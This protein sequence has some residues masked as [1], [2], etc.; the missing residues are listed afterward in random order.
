MLADPADMSPQER[1]NELQRVIAAD[2]LLG[3]LLVLYCVKGNEIDGVCE[4]R[5]ASSET[6]V[7]RETIDRVVL[8][9]CYERNGWTNSS[10]LR[11]QQ[12]L[13]QDRRRWRPP[14]VCQLATPHAAS[15]SSSVSCSEALA[16]TASCMTRLG[17][18]SQGTSTFFKRGASPGK[19]QVN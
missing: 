8:A 7:P 11:H 14:S 12:H 4:S 18:V 1:T 3:V 17:R 9:R 2:D 6:A 10:F 5:S 13:R 16:S 19:T 15:S